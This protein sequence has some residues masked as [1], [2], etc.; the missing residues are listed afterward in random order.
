MAFLDILGDVMGDALEVIFDDGLIWTIPL[1][2]DGKG[3][4]LKGAPASVPCKAVVGETT[5]FMRNEEGYTDKSVGL[6][7]LQR[8]N[9][10]LTQDSEVELTSGA[11]TGERF[12]VA[13]TVRQDPVKC[14]WEVRGEPK[15]G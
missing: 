1:T 9:L 13:G 14:A 6:Y 7:I 10:V 5:E 2:D 4:Y 15:R 3:G 12:L 11:Y 8:D